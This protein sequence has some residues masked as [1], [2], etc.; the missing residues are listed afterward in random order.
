LA[1]CPADNLRNGNNLNNVLITSTNLVFA[2]FLN[3]W[4]KMGFISFSGPAG[5]I[6]I[7]HTVLVEQKHCISD[8]KFLHASN[9]CM[10]PGPVAQQHRMAAARHAGR[11]AAILF[12]LPPVFILPGLAVAWLL[13]ALYC[14]KA[15]RI[16]W[17]GISAGAVLM[18][19]HHILFALN[20][21]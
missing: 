11:A 12:V 4:L 5:Q 2:E 15:N 1:V 6:A 10:L 14:F 19:I 21:R 18:P 17:I 13:G 20:I 9:Y 8:A 7:M 3:F 16:W